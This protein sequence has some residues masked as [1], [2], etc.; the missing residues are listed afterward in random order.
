MVHCG[1]LELLVIE[2]CA[3]PRVAGQLGVGGTLLGSRVAGQLGVVHCGGLE[4]LVSSGWY[5]VAA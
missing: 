1:G 4:L 2:G 5:T 3:G